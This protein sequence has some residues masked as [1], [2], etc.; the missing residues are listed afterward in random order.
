M[1]E[2][3][4]K[5]KI[6][7]F[8]ITLLFGTVLGGGFGND[9]AYAAG[10]DFAGGIGTAA[11]PYLIGT[12]VQLNNLRNA[13]LDAGNHYKL[14]A[15]IDLSGY[16]A[17]GWNSIGD[18]DNPFY[19]HFD[20]DGH[21]ISGLT[22]HNGDSMGLFGI[23]STGG[24]IGNLKLTGVS[25]I[26]DSLVGG[27]VGGNYQ[28]TIDNVT[29][30]GE[31]SGINLLG[32]LAGS[33]YD[34]T[35]LNSCASVELTGDYKVG[36]LV[37]EFMG[38]ISDSCA[39]G[40][41]NGD[42]Y[43]GGLIGFAEEGQ[44]HRSHAAGK[45]NGTDEVGGLIGRIIEGEV[46]QS[47]ATGEVSGNMSVG[48]LVGTQIEIILR[49]S[50]ATG[51]VN[52]NEESNSVGG[53]I[54]YNNDSKILFSYASGE[55]SGLSRSEKLGGL[56]GVNSYI[57]FGEISNSYAMGNVDGGADSLTVGG[58]VGLNM[59][60]TIRNSFASG[61]VNPISGRT[62]F[63]AGGLVGENTYG[64]IQ[65]NYA[66]GKVSGNYAVGGL[67]GSN[68]TDLGGGIYRSFSV[69]DVEGVGPDS[70]FIGGVA[71]YN[72]WGNIENSYAAGKVIGV[73][74]VG[75][76]AGENGSGEILN[77]YSVGQV[78]GITFVGGLVGSGNFG[79][80]VNSLYDTEN[81]GQS[82]SDGGTGLTAAQMQSQ[83]SYEADAANA[84][85]FVSVWGINPAMNGGYPYLRSSL[86][87]LQYAD[88]GSTGGTAPASQSYVP[89][90]PVSVSG[91]MDLVKA[92]HTFAGWS[93]KA[94]G[95]GGIYN[96]GDSFTIRKNTT[97]YAQWNPVPLSNDARLTSTIG[98]VSTDGTAT[99][100]ITGVPYGTTL[101]A[102]KA[103]ITPAAGATF[104]VYEANG[105]TVATALATGY[106]V[107]VTAQDGTTQVT[108]TVTVNGPPSSTDATLTSTIGTVSAGGTASETITGVPYGTTLVAFKA[109]ITPEAG[110]TFEVYEA[111]GT[112]VATAL[113]SGYK[114][115]VTAQDGTTQVTYTVTVN[116]PPPSTDAR[117]TSTIGTVSAGG[118]ASETITGV[119]YGTTL[120][121]F[122]AAITPEAGATFEVYEANGTTVATALASGYKVIVT[123]QDGT[124]QV[125]YT[126]TVNG[127]PSS[128]DATLTSTIGAV[129]AGGT[130]SET[131][132]GVPY[133]TTLTAF[134]AAITP[135]AGATFEVYEA[136]GTTVATALATGYKVIVTAQDG[137][138]QVTYTVTVNTAPPSTVGGGG[139][140]APENNKLIL[141]AGKAGEL[142]LLDEITVTVPANAAD[143][144]IVITIDQLTDPQKLLSD[145]DVLLSAIFEVLTNITENFKNPV[146]ITIKY[147]AAKLPEGQAPAI[148]SYDET[149]KV[150]VKV[151]GGKISGDR[152]SVQ[153]NSLAKFA[154]FSYELSKEPTTD[155]EPS[156]NFRDV[157]GHWAEANILRAL[158]QGIVSGYSDGSFKPNRIITRAEFAV[159]LMNALKQTDERANLSF[160]DAAK[161]GNWAKNAVAVAA[162]AGYIKGYQDGTFR[163]DSAITRAEIAMI[164][165]NVLGLSLE[166]GSSTGFA[167]DSNLPGWAKG[168]IAA[169]HAKDIMKGKPSGEFD[170]AAKATRAEAVTVLLK[171]L[172]AKN[173]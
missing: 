85:D 145:H 95:S 110:A 161:I 132:T 1:L 49:D 6:W 72:A 109:A 61:D 157:V 60:G 113:A 18:S 76:L 16:A 68:P 10:G 27:L 34:G 98:T 104:V 36:G 42:R 92:G 46:S 38:E 140:P 118:T 12:A 71:G 52:G 2:A 25:I 136:N 167:D 8:T 13:Y 75:G 51:N 80:V 78:T 64:T 150:W 108:Y 156:T 169:I 149:K 115:I 48:G 124:T 74:S 168:A 15:D 59:D 142:S 116:G 63:Y 66:S 84:W 153:V 19:G 117:L 138:T 119:P 73:E 26:G 170:P 33:S 91:A 114:V 17:S 126:V 82:V 87:D 67:V 100:T 90:T 128:T 146:T 43:V 160:S 155:N 62:S 7:L 99:E 148:F 3:T 9:K 96:A 173:G 14:I 81:S 171:L 24:W 94:D 103:A 44:I 162:Q 70:M 5:A 54:G 158:K 21:T 164:V 154:V 134:K 4:K 131:I 101:T 122:K 69:G 30:S 88:N 137:T 102:F 50:Y 107:I 79:T 172:D 141:Q 144:D 77:S 45:V 120:V 65:D 121:A 133:G 23:L 125:T 86:V 93:E 29:V 37:G 163:P 40:E 151:E 123:A 139:G 112:T 53:L 97:L 111:N 129:S 83:S 152:V 89:V 165:A 58:L 57:S 56:A 130:A 41:V 127:P 47:Y 135:A 28:G 32:G 20:G 143:K 39:T 105:A 35:I 106:K 147:N 166:T 55:V 31:I 159:M 22:N 11:D